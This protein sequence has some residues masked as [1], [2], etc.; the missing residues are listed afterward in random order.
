MSKIGKMN[1]VRSQH[2]KTVFH[3]PVSILKPVGRTHDNTDDTLSISGSRGRKGSPGSLGI[4]DLDPVTPIKLTNSLVLVDK[5]P[6]RAPGAI[7]IPLLCSYDPAKGL[8]PH[9][10]TGDV[11]Q[12]PRRGIVIFIKQPVG[13]GEMRTSAAN[14]FRSPVHHFY[15]VLLCSTHNAGKRNGR[16]V[17]RHQHHTV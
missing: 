5:M 14:S 15:K 1:K 4:A 13:I 16:I 9:G 6:V 7:R 3:Q 8:V 11:C 12:I 10:G 2:I 17:S